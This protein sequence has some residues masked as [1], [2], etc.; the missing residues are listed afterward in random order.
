M[1]STP[2]FD[3]LKDACGSDDLKDC[4]KFL[5]VQEDTQNEGFIR[6]VSEWS[7]GLREKIVK[8][9]DLMDEGQ[10]FSHF[11][12]AAMDGLECLIEAQATNGEI[13]QAVVRLL[14][15]LR[16]ARAQKRRHVMVK[17]VHD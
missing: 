9:G 15:V 3:E 13:L 14:D 12:V 6:K 4:F 10:T 11:D 5:F 8:F 16:Q 17:E 2:K 1:V 7:N